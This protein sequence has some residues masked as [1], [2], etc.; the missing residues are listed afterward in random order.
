MAKKVNGNDVNRVQ[1][2]QNL[3]QYAAGNEEEMGEIQ[4]PENQ[5]MQMAYNVPMSQMERQPI[6]VL[7]RFDFPHNGT[8]TEVIVNLNDPRSVQYMMRGIVSNLKGA[9]NNGQQTQVSL[10]LANQEDIERVAYERAKKQVTRWNRGERG[11]RYQ[12]NGGW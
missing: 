5:E 7:S 10:K 6:L 12:G 4:I 11:G 8:S 1:E 2:E 3:A 9:V